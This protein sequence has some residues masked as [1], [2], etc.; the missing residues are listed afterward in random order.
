MRRHFQ[1]K[2]LL[3]KKGA[4]SLITYKGQ[5]YKVAVPVYGDYNIA[6]V[7]AAIGTAL[8]FEYHIEDIISMLTSLESREGRFQVIEGPNNRKKLFQTMPIRL[9]PYAL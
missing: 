6:N 9:F 5:S 3:S 4:L 7:L 2:N 8:H 1:A